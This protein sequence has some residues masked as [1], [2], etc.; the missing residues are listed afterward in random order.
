MRE[1]E[2]AA[3]AAKSRASQRWALRAMMR[4]LHYE[5]ARADAIPTTQPSIREKALGACLSHTASA[6]LLLAFYLLL[7]YDI[8]EMANFSAL[9]Y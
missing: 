6:T 2:Y 8:T 9:W 4:S 7:R 1:S 5:D 3:E